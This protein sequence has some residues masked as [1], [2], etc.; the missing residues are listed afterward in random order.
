V[1]RLEKLWAR[2]RGAISGRSRANPSAETVQHLERAIARLQ[3]D[4]NLLSS[5]VG[6]HSDSLRW[7]AEHP[8]FRESPPA[9]PA[10]HQPLVSVV[11]PAL[12]AARSLGRAIDSVR[13]QSYPHWELLIVDDGSGDATPDVAK[14]YAN[15]ERIR[16]LFQ[17]HEGVARA[18]NLALDASGG[19]IIAYLD[20]DNLWDPDYLAHVVGHL[21]LRPE[22]DSVYLGQLV[23]ASQRRFHALRG[24]AFDRAALE[25]ENFIDLNTFAHRRRLWQERGGFDESLRRLGDW[26]LALRYTETK[27][28]LCIPAIGARYFEDHPGSI[29]LREDCWL[30][31]AKILRKHQRPIARGL[32]V[33]YSLEEY[34]QR[35]ETYIRWEIDCMRRFGVEIEV[36]VRRPRAGSPYASDVPVHHGS[37]EAAIHRFQPDVVHAHWLHVAAESA[38]S[39]LRTGRTMTVRGHSF[40]HVPELLAR[41]H[42]HEAVEKLYLFPHFAEQVQSG[43]VRAMD[44][45]IDCEMYPPEPKDRRL[46]LRTAAGLP[47]KDIAI[48]LETALLCTEHR[49]VLALTTVLGHEA[50][51]A[52]LVEENRRLGEPVE[53]LLDVDTEVLAESVRRAGIY[54]HTS[55][56]R[57]H[58]YGRPISVAEALCAGAYVIARDDPD[59]RSFVGPRAGFYRSAEQA[60]ALIHETADWSDDVWEAV[61]RENSERAHRDWADVRVLRPLLDHWTVIA[62]RRRACFAQGP[63]AI[64]VELLEFVEATLRGTERERNG[65]ATHAVGVGLAIQNAGYPRR[66]WQAGFLHAAYGGSRVS[67]WLDLDRRDALAEII[68]AESERLVYLYCAVDAALF[69]ERIEREGRI[70]WVEDRFTGDRL[71]LEGTDLHD[72]CVL[73]VFD[74]LEKSSR[75]VHAVGLRAQRSMARLA[76]G[77]C[78]KALSDFVPLRTSP[79]W[80]WRGR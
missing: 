24:S 23:S 64:P 47:T 30:H 18:R 37:L 10:G 36:H 59:A 22:V 57:A 66:L 32:R 31:H 78:E 21:A 70:D 48:F 61:R 3:H 2:L 79:A 1:N 26:D 16:L 38:Q 14:G 74:E 28:P 34:P 75:G 8:I 56:V 76:G 12:D 77:A 13:A 68:G 65:F 49:F 53:L 63:Q 27:S 72:L 44:V 80:M 19:E 15:D 62:S 6:R 25:R 51:L 60:S 71:R 40:E 54:M 29:S 67:A 46:V 58:R 20:A 43:K 5:D 17:P 69:V 35:S 73:Y 7:V 41:A 45:A 42:D 4:L 52:E 33:L 55:D 9:L 11:M 50:F 39:V